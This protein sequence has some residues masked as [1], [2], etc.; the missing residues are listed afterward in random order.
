MD[1][2]KTV[3]T[4]GAS[5]RAQSMPVSCK[6]ICKAHQWYCAFK[7]RHS[8]MIKK[9]KIQKKEVSNVKCM[10]YPSIQKLKTRAWYEWVCS[11]EIVIRE[12]AFTIFRSGLSNILMPDQQNEPC[13]PKEQNMQ[14]KT[15]LNR[16]RQPQDY[17]IVFVCNFLQSTC[18]WHAEYHFDAMGFYQEAMPEFGNV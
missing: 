11:W 4:L 18:R 17:L 14:N 12:I 7:Y 15:I 13:I 9:K 6:H 10:V 5:I 2:E 1:K 8:F 16:P 3:H